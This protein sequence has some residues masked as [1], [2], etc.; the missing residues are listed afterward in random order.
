MC[1][2]TLASFLARASMDDALHTAKSSRECAESARL[3]STLA[4]AV[5][6]RAQRSTSQTR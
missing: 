2:N 4:S 5:N 6:E 3:G 1:Y